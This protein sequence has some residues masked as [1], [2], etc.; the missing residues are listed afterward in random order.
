[1]QVLDTLGSIQRAVRV[2]ASVE[3][4]LV[5]MHGTLDYEWRLLLQ[6]ASRELAPKVRSLR[7]CQSPADTALGAK[8]IPGPPITGSSPL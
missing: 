2:R 4:E 6:F 5:L 1:M 7:R 8:H 3:L